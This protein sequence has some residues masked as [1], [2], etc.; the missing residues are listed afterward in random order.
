ML[1]G[2]L[3][4]LLSVLDFMLS[5]TKPLKLEAVAVASLGVGL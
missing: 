1:W 5:E 2:R 4:I 3:R